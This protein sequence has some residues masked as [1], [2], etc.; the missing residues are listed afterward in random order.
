MPP[1]RADV[2]GG[3]G[4]QLGRGGHGGAASAWA[5]RAGRLV[6]GRGGRR[7]RR[8]A[9]LRCSPVTAT[10]SVSSRCFSARGAR[11]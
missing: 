6:A 1:V 4:E 3:F 2:A 7:S 9:A 10:T 8:M 11:R 5:A